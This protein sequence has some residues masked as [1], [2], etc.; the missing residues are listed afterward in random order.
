ME[1]QQDPRA[2]GEELALHPR[3]LSSPIHHQPLGVWQCAHFPTVADLL[4]FGRAFPDF[5]FPSSQATG[6]PLGSPQIPLLF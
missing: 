4:L 3:P 1:Q 2:H 6:V 5:P